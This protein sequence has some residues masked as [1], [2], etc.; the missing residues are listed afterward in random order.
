MRGIVDTV[1]LQITLFKIMTRP[2][3]SVLLAT[4]YGTYHVLFQREKMVVEYFLRYWNKRKT[5]K[6]KEEKGRK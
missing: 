2:A 3:A 5:G 1:A 4:L 6:R